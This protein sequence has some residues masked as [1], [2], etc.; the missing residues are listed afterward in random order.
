MISTALAD[1]G[2]GWAK[3]QHV[4]Q[5]T[6]AHVTT[7][8]PDEGEF[9]IITHGKG[10]MWGW[11]ETYPGD[12]TGTVIAGSWRMRACWEIL[13]ISLLW[14][15]IK[16]GS[17]QAWCSKHTNTQQG[18]LLLGTRLLSRLPSTPQ[19]PLGNGFW[20]AILLWMGEGSFPINYFI[21]QRCIH[22]IIGKELLW[23]H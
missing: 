4:R 21:Y 8:A 17:K 5:G 13:I 10:S 15:M 20:A 16:G 22:V 1:R 12:R 11:M 19:C 3:S 2:I 6:K 23:E 9:R 7:P 14:E 18:F